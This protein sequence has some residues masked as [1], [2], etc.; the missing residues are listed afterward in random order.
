MNQEGGKPSK[1][2]PPS[3]QFVSLEQAS[4]KRGKPRQHPA[5]RRHVM[6]DRRR[7]DTTLATE[8]SL[9]VRGRKAPAGD[10]GY[11]AS[12]VD[13]TTGKETGQKEEADTGRMWGDPV[14]GRQ[15]ELVKH[16]PAAWKLD[17]FGSFAAPMDNYKQAALEY[18]KF[19]P[20]YVYDLNIRE[21]ISRF[22]CN[23][24]AEVCCSMINFRGVENPLYLSALR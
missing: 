6:L 8:G 24:Y 21:A 7:R 18:C 2:V 9:V 14:V 5:V 20:L 11:T 4:F 10:S 16:H 1:D 3:L 13:P 12:V 19:C 17:P 23:A 22:R 15:L